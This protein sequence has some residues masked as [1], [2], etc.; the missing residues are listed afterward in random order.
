MNLTLKLPQNKK[1][2]KQ[3]L[4]RLEIYFWATLITLMSESVLVQRALQKVH[5]VDLNRHHVR[6]ILKVMALSGAGL[7][8]GFAVGLLSAQ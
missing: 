6:F 3:V 1:N 2:L 4:T 8:L 5:K 7:I